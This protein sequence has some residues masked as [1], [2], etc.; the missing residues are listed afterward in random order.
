MLLLCVNLSVVSEPR[1]GRK[2]SV[3]SHKFVQKVWLSHQAIFLAPWP[4]SGCQ[5]RSAKSCTQWSGALQLWPKALKQFMIPN[6]AL[7]LRLIAQRLRLTA[8][9]EAL[10]ARKC[11]MSLGKGFRRPMTNESYSWDATLEGYGGNFGLSSFTSENKQF[12]LEKCVDS[13]IPS[14]SYQ[15]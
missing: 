1:A 10:R 12:W 5:L 6:A 14:L 9:T 7:S 8:W 13:A 4:F 2:A 3:V 15:V 11:S